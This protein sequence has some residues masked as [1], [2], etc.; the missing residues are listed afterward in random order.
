M[1]L[2]VSALLMGVA[3][4]GTTMVMAVIMVAHVAHSVTVFNFFLGA[5]STGCACCAT[6]AG[7][8]SSAYRAADQA[9]DHTARDSA[10]GSTGSG[11]AHV[12]ITVVLSSVSS[13]GATC[14]TDA[15]TDSSA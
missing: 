1:L 8:D 3:V 15:C 12:V 7:T 14:A 13:R 4:R 10:T 11:T 5:L 6:D 9:T 2:V